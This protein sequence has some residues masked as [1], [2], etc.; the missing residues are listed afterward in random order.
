MINY[1]VVI[2]FPENNNLHLIIETS[3][4]ASI[5]Y[6]K[7]EN[8]KKEEMFQVDAIS[9]NANAEFKELIVVNVSD[10]S[11]L[12]ESIIADKRFE[13]NMDSSDRDDAELHAKFCG[14]AENPKWGQAPWGSEWSGVAP[15]NR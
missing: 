2:L 4:A 12:V 14:Y 7:L 1:G 10:Y 11:A 9:D 6:R 8:M 15:K 3:A 5:L 13:W